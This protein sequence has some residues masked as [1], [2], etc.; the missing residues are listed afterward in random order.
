MTAPYVPM[1]SRIVQHHQDGTIRV[2]PFLP[3]KKLVCLVGYF[4]GQVVII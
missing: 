1:W 3:R 4:I 2:F